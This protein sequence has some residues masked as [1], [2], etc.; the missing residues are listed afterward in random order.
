MN[1]IVAILKMNIL[2][3]PYMKR[4][5]LL[6]VFYMLSVSFRKHRYFTKNA[7]YVSSSAHIIVQNNL[8]F[9]SLYHIITLHI[10]YSYLNPRPG[11]GLSHLRH[12][13]G[14]GQNDPL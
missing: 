6:E 13:G 3:V 1:V 9:V 11:G 10:K 8:Q 2:Y 7:K 14:G 4:R 5:K 12:G